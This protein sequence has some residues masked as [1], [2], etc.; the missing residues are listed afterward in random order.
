MD[1]KA[2]LLLA[3]LVIAIGLVSYLL[4]FKEWLRWAVLQ[5]EAKYGSGT[6]TVKLRQVY[7]M[8]VSKFP[9]I[10]KLMPFSVFS[11]LVDQ[12]LKWMKEQINK[13]DKIANLVDV[14]SDEK[15]SQESEG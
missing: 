8:A 7:D 4:G 10:T 6:G 2:I 3:A 11:W 15:A 13:N 9:I 14:S 5:A 1:L 12:A